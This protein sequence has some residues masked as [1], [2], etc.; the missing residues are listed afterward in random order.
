VR[1]ITKINLL[2]HNVTAIHNGKPRRESLLPRYLPA[3]SGEIICAAG[4][5]SM[6]YNVKK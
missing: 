5:E 3:D 1:D 6:L 2:A 4:R